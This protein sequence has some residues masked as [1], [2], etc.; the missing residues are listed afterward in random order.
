MSI[1]SMKGGESQ[2]PRAKGHRLR[3]GRRGFSVFGFQFS[4]RSRSS[5]L[6]TESRKLKTPIL[7]CLLLFAVAIP[8][9]GAEPTME[10]LSRSASVSRDR[11][12]EGVFQQIEDALS[13][14]D[15]S[16]AV[17]RLQSVLDRGSGAFLFRRGSYREAAA[18]ADRILAGLPRAGQ[19]AYLRH[20]GERARQQFQQAIRANDLE[21]LL[22]VARRFQRTPTGRAALR[23]YALTRLDQGTAEPARTMLESLGAALSVEGSAFSDDSFAALNAQRSTLNETR[24]PAFEPVWTRSHSL[25]PQAAEVIR[26]GDRF[27]REYG[28]NPFSPWRVQP[29]G[30]R[31]E[32]GQRGRGEE[33]RGSRDGDRAL[34]ASPLA[35]RPGPSALHARRHP[36]LVVTG[37]S[38]LVCLDSESG[39]VLWERE[40]GSFGARRFQDPGEHTDLNRHRNVRMAMLHRLYGESALSR[41]SSDGERVYLVERIEEDSRRTARPRS[42]ALEEREVFPA[43][44]LLCLEAGSGEVVWQTD[45]GDWEP[46]LFAGPPRAVS[47]ELPLQFDRRAGAVAPN[48]PREG[49]P[50][51]VSSELPLQF[52]RRVGAV[53]PIKPREGPP[54]VAGRRLFVQGES[55]S[56]GSLMLLE[57]DPGSGDVL[58]ATELAKPLM[59]LVVQSQETPGPLR[60]T[61]DQ[62][63]HT[64]AGPV[65]IDRE[66]ILCPTGAGV[67]VAVHAVWREAVW[68][69]RYPRS[70]V[71][72]T[73]AGQLDPDPG[74]TGYHWWSGWQETQV[75]ASGDRLAFV[76][77][78]SDRLTVLDRR[79]GQPLWSV[80]RE[81]GL[82]LVAADRTSG[83]VLLGR[84]QA[85]SFDL[86][87]GEPRWSVPSP[88]PAGRG[89]AVGGREQGDRGRGQGNEGAGVGLEEGQRGRGEEGTGGKTLFRTADPSAPSGADDGQRES[90]EQPASAGGYLFPIGETAYAW[91]DLVSGKVTLSRT[92]QE[93][94]ASVEHGLPVRSGP[95]NLQAV[96]ETLYEIAPG[97][98]QRLQP[99]TDGPTV[100]EEETV[101]TPLRIEEAIDNRDWERLVRLWLD[102]PDVDRGDDAPHG[103]QSRG[104]RETMQGEEFILAESGRVRVRLSRWIQGRVIETWTRLDESDREALTAAVRAGIDERIAGAS[105]SPDDERERLIE[106]LRRTPWGERLRVET[107]LDGRPVSTNAE[108]IRVQMDLL[109]LAGRSNGR[110]D[111]SWEAAG[112]LAELFERNGLPREAA[113]WRVRSDPDHPKTPRSDETMRN[114]ESPGMWSKRKPV[115]RRNPLRSDDVFFT[116]IPI[117]TQRGAV[118]DRLSAELDWPGLRGI[119]LSGKDWPHSWLVYLPSSDRFLRSDHELVRGWGL[120]SLLVLQ[121][122]SEVIALSPFLFGG[123]P[124]G[125]V[126]WPTR[127]QSVD[128]LG[129]RS[130]V[131]L[132][133]FH[134]PPIQ[135]PGFPDRPTLRLNEFN[136]YVTAVGPVRPGYL[137]FQQKGMLVAVETATSR[138]LWRRFDLPPR[139]RCLGDDERVVVMETRTGEV[140]VLSATDGRT[141]AMH[142]NSDPVGNGGSGE[143]GKEGEMP[144]FT[145]NDV[146]LERGTSVIVSQGDPLRYLDDADDDSAE[147]DEQPEGGDEQGQGGRG[148]EEQRGESSETVRLMRIDLADRSVLWDREW[149]A[150]AIP[151]ELDPERLGVY[152]RVDGEHRVEF[153]AT[154][155]GETITSHVLDLPGPVTHIASSVG[156]KDDLVLFSR[157]MEDHLLTNARQRHQGYRR[158]FVNGPAIAFD[159]ETGEVLWQKDL[160]NT[161]F[162]LD[163][164]PGLPVFVTAENRYPEHAMDSGTPGSRL[165]CFDRRT[166]ELLH[167]QE[168]LSPIDVNYSLTG[169]VRQ[170]L[171]RLTTRSVSVEIDFSKPSPDE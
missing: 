95:R 171:V 170:Q 149:P 80:P 160:E 99:I 12:L 130:N 94:L 123:S 33:G 64:Q 153:I 40:H 4:D 146:L 53:A 121:L 120:E 22:T 6:K 34:D 107:S 35:L 32:E 41:V 91:I 76:T 62:R 55:Q 18:E 155:T 157:K 75:L 37:P 133:F 113:R 129:D 122:G 16:E 9:A 38:S 145:W 106:L 97:S 134:E 103:S 104:T 11:E 51:A 141:L 166:G 15:W 13:R 165:R 137:C 20:V 101:W 93:P 143:N 5:F 14:E 164:P 89:V 117:E 118:F 48:K 162:P 26:Q 127:T 109:E 68:A 46:F 115:I 74:L 77:P 147:A 67:L 169:D 66:L 168:S 24:S 71:R 57:L 108:F 138:E 100:S 3:V 1:I 98:V 116:P 148:A 79:T 83:V 152:V 56:T 119:R 139:A 158:P 136:Q 47:S 142:R 29:V 50:R 28:L 2:G 42:S 69:Y 65:V 114:D 21:Q 36:A 102:E 60:E 111:S 161:V 88:T 54:R 82:I 8:A 43:M 125:E 110:D 156:V 49:P 163:Q 128:T 27:L 140:R 72:E 150:G 154:E 159:R 25:H 144:R 7:A 90:A 86:E 70:D 30:A 126:L 10:N 85:R 45:G 73:R 124:D 96:G 135:R 131:M 44:R 19:Q 52:D 167:E 58:H 61:P 112:K 87:T 132:S 105:E 39:D 78:E 92:E 81:D 59:P 31:G 84:W 63:R 23:A 17:A 151:F